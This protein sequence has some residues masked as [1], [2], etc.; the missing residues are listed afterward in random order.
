MVLLSCRRIARSS[1]AQAVPNVGVDPRV[2]R[3]RTRA[4]PLEVPNG[5]VVWG[6]RARICFVPGHGDRDV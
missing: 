3:K 5:R 1:A 2:H 4:G 6:P